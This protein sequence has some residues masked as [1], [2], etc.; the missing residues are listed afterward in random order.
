MGV[1]GTVALWGNSYMEGNIGYLKTFGAADRPGGTVRFV[2][3]F[4]QH[5]AFTVEGG[6]E[7]DPAGSGNTGRAVVGVQI[8]QFDAAEGFLGAD[9]SHSDGRPPH[10]IRSA[11]QHGPSRR[12]AASGG[13]RSGPDRHSGR[14]VTLNGSKS[15]DPNGEQLTYQWVQE[16]GPSVAIN[17]ANGAIATFTAAAGS[18]YSFRLTVHNADGL[19]ASARTSVTTTA[20]QKVQILVFTANPAVIQSGQSST[21]AYQVL[22]ADTV[23]ISGLGS[24]NPSNGSIP[25]TP[26]QTTTYTLTATNAN[27]QAT[28]TATVTVQTPQPQILSCTATPMNIMQGESA[29][30]V[31]AT[32]NATS[33]SISGIGSVPVT[34]NITVTPTTTTTYTISASNAVASTT[35]NVTVSVTAG[36]APRI[37]R[38]TAAPM[39]ITSGQ[40]STLVWQVENATTVTISPTVGTVGLVGTQDVTPTQTT[41]YTITATNNFGQATANVT[42]NVQA[43]TVTPT[44]AITSFTANPATSPAP[45]SPVVLTCLATGAVQVAISGIAPVNAQGQLTVNPQ[46]TTTYTCFATSSNGQTVTKQ[47]TVPVT[48]A[49]TGGGGTPPT[50]T[51]SGNGCSPGTIVG[52]STVGT[53]VCQ[54][55]VRQ[56]TLDFSGSTSPSGNAPLTFSLVNQNGSADVLSPNSSTP[57][58]QLVEG[59]GDYLFTLTVTDSKGNQTVAMVDVQYVKQFI[60]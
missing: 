13:R 7:R 23:T 46:T 2:F 14:H 33:V 20:P 17:N 21:L 4:E 37:I 28:A 41:T 16:A 43:S 26:A 32:Q 48:P 22:N 60:N 29:T 24:V 59:P 40:A 36:T 30:I 58:V 50:I 57:I 39:T 11:D 34:G 42:V 49:S 38:F 56:I 47:L 54:T 27:G 8:G 51:V 9:Q 35:C 44:L 31:Y 19:Q 18:S 53:I 1:S 12:D 6:R 15:Y 5:F 10:P 52:G 25:V 3:P 45:G 55:V